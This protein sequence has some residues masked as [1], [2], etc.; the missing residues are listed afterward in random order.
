MAFQE[1]RVFSNLAN[2]VTFS[3]ATC[4]AQLKLTFHVFVSYA[5]IHGGRIVSHLY[6]SVN[7]P[8]MSLYLMP[9]F[10]WAE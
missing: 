9:Q 10:K 3:H 7:V 2:H 1:S 4:I 8:F 5:A 6:K